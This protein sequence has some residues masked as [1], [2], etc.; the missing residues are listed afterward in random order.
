M[1]LEADGI[2]V[3]SRRNLRTLLAKL[4]GAPTGSACAILGGDEAPGFIVK[5]EEDEVHYAER[6]AGLMHPDTEAALIVEAGG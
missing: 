2:L 5:A 1:R 4:D 3:L 6:P